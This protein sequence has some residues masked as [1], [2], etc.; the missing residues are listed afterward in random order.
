MINSTEI[1]KWLREILIC[2]NKF[3][4]RNKVGY[5][6]VCYVFHLPVRLIQEGTTLY[7]VQEYSLYNRYILLSCRVGKNGSSMYDISIYILNTLLNVTSFR[8]L[9]S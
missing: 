1:L 8:S 7:N 5:C 9:L 4:L 2:R 6:V 3:L